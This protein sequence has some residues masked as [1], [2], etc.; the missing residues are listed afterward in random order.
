ML[1]L[2]RWRRRRRLVA[3]LRQW[4]CGL[5]LRPACWN[6]GR[7]KKT[8]PPTHLSLHVCLR[9]ERLWK[10]TAALAVALEVARKQGAFGLRQPPKEWRQ[11]SEEVRRLRD[12][13]AKEAAVAAGKRPTAG[14]R[15]PAAGGPRAGR[16]ALG[17][18]AAAVAW[19]QAAGPPLRLLSG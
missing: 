8:H 12:A 2:Q 1:L 18:A 6:R 11:Y 16:R 14:A 17:T 3:T 10:Q 13:A 4:R 9:Q 15:A 7:E 5:G 19:G